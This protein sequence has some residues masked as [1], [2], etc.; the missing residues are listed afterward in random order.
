VAPVAGVRLRGQQ[1]RARTVHWIA[2]REL[3]ERGITVNVVSPDPTDSGE[4]GILRSATT[5]EVRAEVAKQTPLGALGQVSDIANVVAFLVGPEG[6]WVTA[7][8][9]RVDGGLVC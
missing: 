9:I 3:G 8:N 4:G 6:G 5:D 2:T 7:Q 1:G